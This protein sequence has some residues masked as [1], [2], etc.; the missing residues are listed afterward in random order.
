MSENMHGDGLP[1]SAT[2][3]CDEYLVNTPCYGTAYELM[4]KSNA[5]ELERRAR[6]AEARVAELE[7]ILQ[8]MNAQGGLGFPIHRRIHQALNLP[9]P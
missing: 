7:R 2:P 3:F 6:K 1:V 8:W 4:S 5:E 9:W